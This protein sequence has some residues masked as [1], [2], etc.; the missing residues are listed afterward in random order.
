MVSYRSHRVAPHQTQQVPA[1]ATSDD[2]TSAETANLNSRGTMGLTMPRSAA[3]EGR[4]HWTY[5]S[6]GE[7]GFLP[8]SP[9]PDSQPSLSSGLSPASMRAALAPTDKRC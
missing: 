7:D 1:H 5:Q 4:G 3:G 2:S 8:P 9:Q 6:R